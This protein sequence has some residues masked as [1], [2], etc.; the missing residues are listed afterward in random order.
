[1]PDGTVLVLEQV[2]SGKEH[3]FE[4]GAEPPATFSNW[5]RG[6]TSP[7]PQWTGFNTD[8]RNVV[9]WLSRHGA[10]PGPPLDFDWWWAST[11]VDEFGEEVEDAE[12]ARFT[13]SSSG[14]GTMYADRPWKPHTGTAPDLI[15]AYSRFPLSR[16]AGGLRPLRVYDATGAV[17]AEFDIPVPDTSAAPTWEPQSLPA[18]RRDD[19][20]SVTVTGLGARRLSDPRKG[21]VRLSNPRPRWSLKPEFAVERNGQPAP[22]WKAEKVQVSDALGNVAWPH[23]CQLST[24]ESAWNLELTLAR[25]SPEAFAADEQW[26]SSAISLPSANSTQ[27]LEEQATVQNVGV[28]LVAVGHGPAEYSEIT[29]SGS[30]STHRTAD[31]ARGSGMTFTTSLGVMA[32]RPGVVTSTIHISGSATHLLLKLKNQPSEHR[33][34]FR[35]T[36]DQ[37]RDVPAAVV[38]MKGTHRYL[39]GFAP[40]AG[41]QSIRVTVFVH[42]TRKVELRVAPPVVDDREAA[43]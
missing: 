5:L 23:D 14:A 10:Q 19:D 20:L 12:P 2:T 40:P 32:S 11:L 29:P 34:M 17:V 15:V 7:P 26:T 18:V 39:L 36:D 33:E 30:D 16:Q 3:R 22:E 43:K 35:I 21:H 24:R 27:P 38:G 4:Y 42:T 9:P 13:Q 31:S 1:M 41:A 25:T 8:G 37:G 28:S 6:G